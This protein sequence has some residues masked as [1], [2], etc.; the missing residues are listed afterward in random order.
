MNKEG[1]LEDLRSTLRLFWV[2][3]VC[4]CHSRCAMLPT[5]FIWWNSNLV[6]WHATTYHRFIKKWPVATMLWNIRAYAVTIILH[7]TYSNNQAKR[8]LEKQTNPRFNQVQPTYPIHSSRILTCQA[9]F[10]KRAT[11]TCVPHETCHKKPPGKLIR[12]SRRSLPSATCKKRFVR[13][14]TDFSGQGW[15]KWPS[16]PVGIYARWCFKRTTV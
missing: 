7:W 13:P 8:T 4:V 5:F 6:I 11:K 16:C 12:V 2:L 14:G 10:M 3:S 9:Q 15:V 1:F